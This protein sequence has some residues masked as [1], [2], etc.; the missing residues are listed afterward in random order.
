[1]VFTFVEMKMQRLWYPTQNFT[2][3]HAHMQTHLDINEFLASEDRTHLEDVHIKNV[4]WKMGGFSPL[5]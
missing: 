1:M 2:H 3:N 5:S 4:S